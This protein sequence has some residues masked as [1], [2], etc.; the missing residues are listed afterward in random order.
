M[1]LGAGIPSAAMLVLWDAAAVAG[2]AL[3]SGG[4]VRRFAPTLSASS[5]AWLVA[6]L[7]PLMFP[8]AIGLLFGNLDVF[9]PLLYGLMLLAM[10]EPSASAD[11][12][13][14]GVATAVAGLAQ[15]HPGSTG[16]ALLVRAP[17]S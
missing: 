17:A 15:L 8:L 10:A 7:V 4:L 11:A 14:G 9:F 3:V 12:A 6:A 13:Q 1:S 16:L 5:V 2:L